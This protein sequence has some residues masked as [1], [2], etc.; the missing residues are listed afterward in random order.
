MSTGT[1][2]SSAHCTPL[3]RRQYQQPAMRQPRK[4]HRLDPGNLQSDL[5]IGGIDRHGPAAPADHV[6]HGLAV[7]AGNELPA[8]VNGGNQLLRGAELRRIE[9]QILGK[10]RQFIVRKLGE[11]NSGLGMAAASPRPFR[12]LTAG[13]DG[14]DNSGGIGGVYPWMYSRN[15]VMGVSHNPQ[16]ARPI[17]HRRRHRPRNFSRA[18]AVPARSHIAGSATCIYPAPLK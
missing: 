17:R 8:V 2:A 13:S 11:L 4:S 10:I 3:R 5:L 14:F 1:S 15:Q 9:P 16:H 6:Q 7:Q 12:V 18:G